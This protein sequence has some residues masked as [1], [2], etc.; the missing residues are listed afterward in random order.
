[1]QTIRQQIF[2]KVVAA[3]R[4]IKTTNTWESY[5]MTGNYSTNVGNNVHAWRS[6]PFSVDELNA[7]G[8]G[9]VVRDLDAIADKGDTRDSRTKWSLHIQVI[10]EVSGD[11]ADS[12]LRTIFGDLDSAFYKGRST[13]W[14]GLSN[15][16]RP[17]VVRSVLEQE[18]ARVAGGVYEVYIDYAT[19]AFN[20]YNGN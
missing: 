8:G 6:T 19:L 2:D 13:G 14:D 20:S 15:D 18:S 17:R 5:G 12:A 3:L 1:M 9:L 4:D 11:D 16:T 7:H 10:V